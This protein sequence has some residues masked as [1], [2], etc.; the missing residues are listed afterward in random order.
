MQGRRNKRRI[1]RDGVCGHPDPTYGH[2]VKDRGPGD[3]RDGAEDQG[4]RRKRDSSVDVF[5]L[6]Y[7]AFAPSLELS[8][9]NTSLQPRAAAWA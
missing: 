7:L 6:V 5:R 8:A 1:C 9:C 4:N 2:V 3:A